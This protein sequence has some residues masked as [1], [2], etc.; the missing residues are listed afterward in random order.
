MSET[1]RTPPSLDPEFKPSLAT[2]LELP[3]SNPILDTYSPFPTFGSRDPFGLDNF[4]LHPNDAVW[5]Y[6]QPTSIPGEELP[7]TERPKNHLGLNRRSMM[8]SSPLAAPPLLT[9]EDDEDGNG[10]VSP[11]AETPVSP[12]PRRPVSMSIS[13]KGLRALV[14]RKSGPTISADSP[15]LTEVEEEITSRPTSM[16]SLLSSSGSSSEGSCDGVK[17]P[18][19]AVAPSPAPVDVTAC[20]AA[21]LQEDERKVASSSRNSWRGWLGSKR[22]SFLGMR[23]GESGTTLLESPRA[24]VVDLA[25]E[26]PEAGPS[27]A[28]A[29]ANSDAARSAAVLRRLSL[30]KLG[31]L[32]MPSAH[33]LAAVLARQVGNLP[34]EVA[35][36]IP[37]TKR[38]YPMSVNRL[39]N[40]TEL[41][42]AQGGLRVALGLRNIIRKIDAGER[43]Q[44]LKLSRPAPKRQQTMTRARGVAD[45][46]ARP[47]FE[48]R[49]VVYS[50]DY[51]CSEV[52]TARPG[53]A[54]WDIDFSE[55]IQA[56]AEAE[57]APPALSSP[58]SPARAG[59]PPPRR[60]P[61]LRVTNPSPDSKQASLPPV[62]PQSSFRN[63]RRRPQTWEDSSDEED[64]PKTEDE[65]VTK[66]VSVAPARP[67]A[68]RTTTAP[69]RIRESKVLDCDAALDMLTRARERRVEFNSGVIE[70]RAGAEERRKSMAPLIEKRTPSSPAKPTAER[71]LPARRQSTATLSAAQQTT[72]RPTISHR[73][74]SFSLAGNARP[75]PPSSTPK[76]TRPPASLPASPRLTSEPDRRRVVSTYEQK[77]QQRASM[78]P[79][80]YP[81]Y[82]AFVPVP[83]AYTRHPS[84]II[85]PPQAYP[86][87]PHASPSMY[88]QPPPPATGRRRERPVA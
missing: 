34:N 88:F 44:D 18:S 25:P 20:L 85:P 8:R 53:Y 54:I 64:E 69:A 5:E 35:F 11:A 45:F 67:V 19:D 70:R 52:S 22:T 61:V 24:S 49:M 41:A 39:K 87:F 80:P 29:A 63:A 15:E 76:P 21:A 60:Q 50:A 23:G 13:G 30:I 38:V 9:E 40:T 59:P 83:V 14:G 65:T 46:V 17:T 7:E 36:S 55:Y 37:A 66:R 68:K 4:L 33:P 1:L 26:V 48:E 81:Q 73:S 84:L 28:V 56:L 27:S 82:P 43:P 6:L 77:P 16:A 31:S 74:S 3:P 32:R 58:A 47:P 71:Q 79:V 12:R 86:Q 75:A 72:D 42:P 10:T 2:D 57:E 51:D 78:Y 62:I